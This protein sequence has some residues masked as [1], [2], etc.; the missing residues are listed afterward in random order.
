MKIDFIINSM[1]GGGAERVLSTLA[2]GFSEKNQVKIIT[3]NPGTNYNLSSEI[4]KVNLYNRKLIKNHSVR[5][6]FNLLFFYSSKN[7]RPDVLISFL[8]GNSLISIL[9]GKI[10]KIKIIVS[11]HTNHTAP[12][13]F[14]S[15]FTRKKLYRF[16]DYTTILT[17]FDKLY[18][19]KFK[20]N[21]V[22][23]PNPIIIPDSV[24][25]ISERE[26]NILLIGD[27][28]RFS[29]KGFD[30]ILKIIAPI[31]LE[32]LDWKMTFVGGGNTGIK[33]LKKM[34]KKLN[35]NNQ[36]VF[37]GFSKNIQ[38][39]M[40]GSQIFILPSKFEGL[41]MGLMEA[42]SNG[43]AC[44]SYDCPSGPKDLIENNYNGLLIE[45][46]NHELMKFGI[47]NLIKDHELR[48]RLA[49]AAPKS[50]T[51]YSLENILNNWRTIFSKL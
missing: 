50:M 7:N 12:V 30:S 18:F 44:I 3:F 49:K 22:I 24:K 10:F 6:F 19:E 42:L 33:V 46:Q 41:P 38:E 17:S 1:A 37:T 31:L 51:P 9:V 14:K 8:P 25:P 45:N 4:K 39:L 5:S 26:K 23:M 28:N 27:L 21:V 15:N 2:N 36:V 32:N 20:A 43:L 34:A 40:Q 47:S 35:I 13:D 11:E 48:F 29:N 16:A